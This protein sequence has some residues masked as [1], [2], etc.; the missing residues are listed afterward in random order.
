MVTVGITGGIG[1]GKTEVCRIWESMGAFILNADD[2]AKKI[3]NEKKRVRSRIKESF[4]EQ[5]Y[6]EDGTLNREYL[7]EEAFNR[8]RIEE[9][10]AIVHPEIPAAS[11]RIMEQAAQDGFEVF[12]YE[13]ALLLQHGRPEFL[14]IVV[15]VLADQDKRIERVKKRDDVDRDQVME[16]MEKQ[17][18]FE[19]LVPLADYVIRNNGTLHQLRS[20]AA[21]LYQTFLDSK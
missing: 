13:A 18:D 9:L 19:S 10:N 17:Q 4:G 7:A 5:A 20:K 12:V 15:L 1:S 11:R 14:D 21:D 16:R 2:L 6:R 3:M 8:G